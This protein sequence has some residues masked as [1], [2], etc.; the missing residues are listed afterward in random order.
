MIVCIQCDWY[1]KIYELRMRR[2]GMQE[3]EKGGTGTLGSGF[4][5]V[6]EVKNAP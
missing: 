2:F 5:L 1:R 3:M 6:W 4:Y